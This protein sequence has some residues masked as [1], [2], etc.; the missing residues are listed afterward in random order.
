ME[1]RTLVSFPIVVSVSQ[2][3]FCPCS[4]T[5][6]LDFLSEI[7]QNLNDITGVKFDVIPFFEVEP[8]TQTNSN[9]KEMY[10]L[11]YVTK[12]S[13]LRIKKGSLVE[14]GDLLSKSINEQCS[15]HIGDESLFKTPKIRAQSFDYE[16]I[17]PYCVYVNLLFLSSENT[18]KEIE[19]QRDDLI[20]LKVL[21][22]S[23]FIDEI[24]VCSFAISPLFCDAFF[25]GGKMSSLVVNGYDFCESILFEQYHSKIN[26]LMF[27]DASLKA[28]SEEKAIKNKSDVIRLWWHGG[29][30]G[31]VRFNSDKAR[32]IISSYDTLDFD[33]PDYIDCQNFALTNFL[34]GINV[35]VYSI[36]DEDVFIYNNEDSDLS[37]LSDLDMPLK[38]M[39]SSKSGLIISQPRG[40]TCSEAADFMEPGKSLIESIEDIIQEMEGTGIGLA[41]YIRH[42]SGEC[43]H[44]VV[45]VFGS[46][47]DILFEESFSQHDITVKDYN[48]CLHTKIS[49]FKDMAE[50][51]DVDFWNIERED[52]YIIGRM[53]FPR[54]EKHEVKTECVLGVVFYI[55]SK[56]GEKPKKNYDD[57]SVLAAIN[58]FLFYNVLV[59]NEQKNEMEI[60]VDLRLR[61]ISL[62]NDEIETS[63][64]ISEYIIAIKRDL[65][66]NEKVK[67]SHRSELVTDSYPSYLMVYGVAVKGSALVLNEIKMSVKKNYLFPNSSHGIKIKELAYNV[68]NELGLSQEDLSHFSYRFV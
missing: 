47:G 53:G 3:G 50:R 14:C 43:F 57:K 13:I 38:R 40:L 63:G 64:F 18:E 32:V 44:L 28:L 15:G 16:S 26:E 9:D 35:E 8:V 58:D 41:S 59:S 6:A 22:E 17:I 68:C 10:S 11:P 31:Y 54:A 30:F 24:G 7:Q 46:Y 60:K 2:D 29:E 1:K 34:N 33:T 66:E 56:S 48:D 19:I 45:T 21:A 27:F 23:F 42:D 36:L 67:L 55:G 4:S 5:A 25:S 49:L 52:D 62:F 39:F 65:P 12:E 51:L 37:V 20:G 61:A